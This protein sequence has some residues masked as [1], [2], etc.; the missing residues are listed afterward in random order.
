MTK[1]LADGMEVE[2][3]WAAAGRCA[4]NGRVLLL[5]LSLLL[6]GWKVDV[7]AGA[8]TVTLDYDRGDGGVIRATRGEEPGPVTLQSAKPALDYPPPDFQVSE[9]QIFNLFAILL[10]WLF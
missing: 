9:K 5:V 3:V 1:V 7:R 8:D 4:Y 2:V 6:A 10:F